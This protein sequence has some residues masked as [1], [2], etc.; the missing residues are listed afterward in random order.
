M[1]ENRRGLGRGLSALLGEAEEISHA[2]DPAEGVRDIPI[3][4]IHRNPDQPRRHFDAEEIADLER[5]IRDKG[6]LQPILV[7]PSPTTPGEFEI[8]AGER[9][10][11]AAQQAGMTAIPALV[12]ALNDDRAYEIAIV[13]NVQRTDLNPLE[14]AQAY[15][16]LVNRFGHTQDQIAQA[17]GKSRSH[18][19]NTLRLAQLPEGVQAHVLAGRLTAGHARALLTA[20]NAEAL[21]DQVAREGLSV[22]ET[23]ALARG[24]KAPA[25]KKTSGPRAKAKDA[26][27]EALEADLEDALGLSVDIADRGG[28]GE[29]RIKYATLEQL[30]EICRRLTRQ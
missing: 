5:S 12:R 19:A 28:V 27:T 23:E 26:D 15:A 25:P 9:R 16:V 17:I 7:R 13:E 1:A 3:E 2:V 8:V 10:W 21:A 22:R 14:E 4:L 29:L 6:I 11:R 30:D 18:V 20:D 24:E